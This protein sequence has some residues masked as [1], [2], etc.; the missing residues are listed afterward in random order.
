MATYAEFYSGT[1][2]QQSSGPMCNRKFEE[3]VIWP[4]AD[5]SGSTTKD[6][7]ADGLHPVVAIGGRT[8]DDGRPNNITGVVVSYSAVS[9]I[10]VVNIA[11]CQ[12]V[13]AYVS[14]IFAYDGGN[15]PND[16]E[17]APVIGQSVY[18]DDSDDLGE[19]CTLSMS[20]SND[21]G[22]ANPLAGNL[23]YCQD[24][25]VDELIGGGTST[26]WGPGWSNAASEEHLVCVLLT[27]ATP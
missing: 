19:G 15:G 24:E 25:Y 1:D 6:A 23:I 9:D 10:A 14:N 12:I 4:I 5:N 7:L 21:E 18:V 16:W 27:N 22:V 3:D 13:R 20:A 8:T 17:D 11:P 2:W 26:E